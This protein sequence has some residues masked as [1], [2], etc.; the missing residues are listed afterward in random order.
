MK[1][2]FVGA[3]KV[4]QTFGRYLSQN[5]HQVVGYYSKTYDHALEASKHVNGTAFESLEALSKSADIIL[6]TVNDQMIQVVSKELCDSGSVENVKCLIHMSGALPSSIM[7]R[8]KDISYASIHPMQAFANIEEALSQMPSTVFGIEGD[9]GAVTIFEDL[10]KGMGNE[11]IKL[12]ETQKVNYHLAAVIASNYL[13]TLVHMGLAQMKAIGIE[14]DTGIKALLPL[15][16]GTLANIEAFGTEKSLTG[17]IA[18]GDFKTVEAHLHAMD[19]EAEALY[20]HLGRATLEI[21]QTQ[22][23]PVEK[24]QALR[25]LLE[26]E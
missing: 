12:T 6:L 7:E 22:A 26:E 11:V 24:V 21:A 23:M 4:G 8:Y 20:K 3:G 5:G 13:V 19:K 14:E 25:H 2:G 1:F 17:P 18:R 15:I 10:L 16:K 9:S